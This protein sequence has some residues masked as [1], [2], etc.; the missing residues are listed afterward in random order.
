[1]KAECAA[2]G[3]TGEGGAEL[4]ATFSPQAA[5]SSKPA[6]DALSGELHGTRSP[7]PKSWAAL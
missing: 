2:Q 3:A 1:M 7:P 5:F 6:F 4:Q